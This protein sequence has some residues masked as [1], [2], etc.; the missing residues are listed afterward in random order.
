MVERVLLLG[1]GGEGRGSNAGGGDGVFRKKNNK[2]FWFWSFRSLVRFKPAKS[3][4]PP[5]KPKQRERALLLPLHGLHPTRI[6][7]SA[8]VAR[9]PSTGRTDLQ[10]VPN[11]G[12]GAC[13]FLAFGQAL[14][15]LGPAVSAPAILRELAVDVVTEHI[16]VWG[17]YLTTF[18]SRAFV[19]DLDDDTR[20][21]AADLAPHI[22]AYRARMLH[23][24]S[25]GSPHEAAALAWLFEVD[26][27][28][29]S[30]SATPRTSGTAPPVGVAWSSRGWIA[31]TTSGFGAGG[32]LAAGRQCAVR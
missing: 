25:W 5:P 1:S 31:A 26:V 3:R 20:D 19:G 32:V 17:M 9:T 23:K 21:H 7:R 15:A 11:E 18:G 24:R 8:S 30:R 27:Q 22:A 28:I 14:H 4:P 16:F 29:T 10:L 13:M 12:G 6:W 2:L